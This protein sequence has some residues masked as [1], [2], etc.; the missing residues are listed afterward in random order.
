M[1]GAMHETMH[2]HAQALSLAFD[3]AVTVCERARRIRET[4]GL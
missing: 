1:Y 3:S 2:T 4:E